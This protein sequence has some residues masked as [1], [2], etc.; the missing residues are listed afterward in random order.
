MRPWQ[1]ANFRPAPDC[2]TTH[3]EM[4]SE[5]LITDIPAFVRYARILKL[6]GFRHVVALGLRGTWRHDGGEESRIIGESSGTENSPR[7]H[8]EGAVEWVS[9]CQIFRVCVP[10]Y[11]RRVFDFS[12]NRRIDHPS[13][14]TGQGHAASAW[15]IFPLYYELIS[16]DRTAAHL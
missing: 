3:R 1:P 16:F 14:R 6:G 8:R 4:L 5:G 15:R 11:A 10:I 2:G 12:R 13:L 9:G 7:L